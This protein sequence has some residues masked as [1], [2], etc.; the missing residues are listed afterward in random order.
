MR[1]VVG[2]LFPDYLNIYAD[3]GNMAVLARRAAWRGHEL[4]VR[5]LGPG[6]LVQ[7]GE[8][9]L[10]YVG[11]GQDREQELIARALMAMGPALHEA[12]EG[13]AAIV[14]AGG[15]VVV[16]PEAKAFATELWA[17]RRGVA[18]PEAAEALRD[19]QFDCNRQRC[20]P[21]PGSPASLAAW[22][23]RRVPK[24]A[25]L[26]RLCARASIVILKADVYPGP[27]CMGRTVLTTADFAKGGA[28]EVYG[29]PAGWRFVW[30]QPLR[31]DRPW[32][33]DASE[34]G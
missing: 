28:A 33:R 3:R 26:E 27:S 17:R 29:S 20:W 16:R 15:A 2:H 22:W 32:S 1:I 30:S 7:P 12:I 25:D 6:D 31:G 34:A 10:Y 14:Q 19:A 23:T 11:G 18:L 24:P 21:K 4:E 5:P 8:H 13:G 9:D